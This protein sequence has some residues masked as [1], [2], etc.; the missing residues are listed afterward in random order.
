MPIDYL[1]EINGD[2]EFC[3]LVKLIQPDL[4]VLGSEYREKKSR[5]PDVPALFIHDSGIRTS[6][7]VR[8]IRDGH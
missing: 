5:I 4:R 8:R 7:I 6:E 2:E 1:V 3:R